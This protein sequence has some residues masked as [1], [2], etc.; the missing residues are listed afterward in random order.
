M[1]DTVLMTVKEVARYLGLHPGNIYKKVREGS[2]PAVRIGRSWRFPK[3][4]IDKWL[5]E[6][7]EEPVTNKYKAQKA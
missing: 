2:I 7:V 6:K 5:S 3:A 1:V 4:M